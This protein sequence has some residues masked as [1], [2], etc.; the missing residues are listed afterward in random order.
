MS[1]LFSSLVIFTHTLTE[2]KT[3]QKNRKTER[4]TI[5]LLKPDKNFEISCCWKFQK[6]DLF[7]TGFFSLQYK[8]CI[9]FCILEKAFTLK[10]NIS[11]IFS[12]NGCDQNHCNITL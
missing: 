2:T 5:V 4:R 6:L 9:F 12:K 11:K 8:H 3:R 10:D 1:K 7:Q